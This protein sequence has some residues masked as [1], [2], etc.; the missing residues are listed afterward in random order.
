ML[1]LATDTSGKDGRIALVRGNADGTCQLLES[2]SLDGGAF[3]AQLVPQIAE[4]LSKHGFGKNDIGGFV[5]VS[6]PGSF[7]GLRV[8]L[9]AVK[10]LAEILG[11]PIAAVSLL[12]ATA[13]ASGEKGKVTSVLD[14]GRQQVYVGEYQISRCVASRINESLATRNEFLDLFREANIVTPSSEI[15]AVVRGA[16]ISVR[17]IPA[18]DLG[19]VADLGW[20]KILA[21]E[22]VAPENLEA[23]YI[24]RTHAEVLLK[25]GL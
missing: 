15:A 1:L 8:G 3:S 16:G 25:G 14:A 2:S 11:K 10:A 12:E 24:S 13:L 18:P 4:L 20:N 7:T 5:L 21:G 22:T 19:L 9:A 17:L 6:G 23:N